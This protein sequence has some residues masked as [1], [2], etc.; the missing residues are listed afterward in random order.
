M[1]AASTLTRGSWGATAQCLSNEY[2]SKFMTNLL[3]RQRSPRV[4]SLHRLS[5]AGSRAGKRC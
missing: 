4:F 5:P 1:L 2:L 3:S